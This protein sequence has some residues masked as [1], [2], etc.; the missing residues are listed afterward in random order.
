M[1]KADLT[2]VERIKQ[3]PHFKERFA[4]LTRHAPDEKTA[5]RITGSFLDYLADYAADR[6]HVA[7][8]IGAERLPRADADEINY[9]ISTYAFNGAYPGQVRPLQRGQRLENITP[10]E[11]AIATEDQQAVE[12]IANAAVAAAKVNLQEA[13]KASRSGRAIG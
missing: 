10:S 2:V 12:R 13:A 6:I 3:D 1:E 4:E 5:K 11:I 7:V 9:F 8:G